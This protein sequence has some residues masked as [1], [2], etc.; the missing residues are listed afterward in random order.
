MRQALF[1][2]R[3]S[4]LLRANVIMVGG[5]TAANFGAYLFH[6]VTGRLLSTSEFGALESLISLFNILSVP[7]SAINTVVVKFVSGWW[8]KGEKTQIVGLYDRLHALLRS[9]FFVGGG[10]FLLAHT[11]VM[12]F[13]HISS[14][15]SFL[16]L[17]AAVF[18]GF[19]QFLNRA[20]LQGLAKF[21]ELVITQFIEAYGKLL[22]GIAVLALGFGSPG[23]FGAFV[24]SGIVSFIYTTFVV[25]RWI[26]TSKPE[27]RA[28]LKPLVKSTIPSFFMTLSLM[29][30]FNTDVVLVRH[31]LSA[32]ES[33]L[34]SSLSVLG[35]II[36]FGLSPVAT[37]MLPMVVDAHTKGRGAHKIF[38][39]SL[40]F[41][42][43]MAIA[44]TAFF[45]FNSTQVVRLLIGSQYQMVGAYLTMFSLFI[46]LCALLQVMV[47][48]FF[49]IHKML[50]ILL[51]G[52]GAVS[53]A[54]M[55]VLTHSTIL[56]VIQASLAI[57]ASLFLALLLYYVYVARA[58][59]IVGYRSLF[60]A[61][62]NY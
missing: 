31:Y 59:I 26:G 62:K 23:A 27:K 61:R 17:D 20:M 43:L 48:F 9:L 12:E 3:K 52:V 42:S 8:S 56:S 1:S 34:Y 53:Q 55:I 10:I 11:P 40:L 24:A 25:R 47:L 13:L 41:T 33:G 36:F 28:S 51:L 32:H 58:E 35:K 4:K 16:F 18:F 2:L 15:A 39:V 44:V 21:S 22:L 29:S 38:L 49:S 7:L 6:L 50:P 14:F 54:I 19:L 46:S 60:P 30:L 5:N 45:S 37:A 57:S